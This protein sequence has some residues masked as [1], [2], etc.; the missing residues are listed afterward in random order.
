MEQHIRGK[1]PNILYRFVAVEEQPAGQPERGMVCVRAEESSE[2]VARAILVADVADLEWWIKAECYSNVDI[3]LPCVLDAHERPPKQSANDL[4]AR[5]PI[6]I[7]KDPWDFR[8]GFSIDTDLIPDDANERVEG[9]ILYDPYNNDNP[10]RLSTLWLDGQSFGVLQVGGDSHRE[11][12]VTD[13]RVFQAAVAY[14]RSLYV[15]EVEDPRSPI[16]PDVPMRKLTYFCGGD[17]A[18]FD[19]ED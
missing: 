4:Y 6:R 15:Y 7:T 18:W 5:K 12:F 1:G 13:D 14:L 9:R 19:E 2:E 17:A 10:H 16:D 11:L 3:G 8:W